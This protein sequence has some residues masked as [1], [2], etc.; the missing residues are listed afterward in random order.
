MADPIYLDNQATTP[1][2]PED[3]DAM[4]PFFHEKFQ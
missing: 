2:D 1:L 3:M 4:L